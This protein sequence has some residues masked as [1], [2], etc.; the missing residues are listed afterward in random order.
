MSTRGALEGKVRTGR[1]W[2]TSRSWTYLR[3]L[4]RISLTTMLL[5]SLGPEGAI[6]SGGA[7]GSR[8]PSCS[9]RSRILVT[10]L[11]TCSRSNGVSVVCARGGRA[12]RGVGAERG[13]P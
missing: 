6:G 5:S 12:Q 9:R 2:R 13:A 10:V 11:M 8:T 1:T 3:S 4:S 7:S